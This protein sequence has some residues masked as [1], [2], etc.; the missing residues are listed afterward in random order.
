[1]SKSEKAG[2][3][4]EAAPPDCTKFAWGKAWWSSLQSHDGATWPALALRQILQKSR[5][6]GILVVA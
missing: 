4:D 6:T 1:M 2:L 3:P 5:F